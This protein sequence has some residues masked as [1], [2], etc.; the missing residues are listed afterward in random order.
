MSDGVT[1]RELDSADAPAVAALCGQLGY[2][3]TA[4]EIERRVGRLAGRDD[5]A[6]V[7]AVRGGEVVGWIH[8]CAR[9]V[10]ESEPDVE[11]AGL[12]V[13][14]RH[15]GGGIGRLLMAY[16]DR[17]AGGRGRTLVRVRS[18]VV[19]ESAHAFYKGLGFRI[20]KTQHTFVK[21]VAP[22]TP[23]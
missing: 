8:L 22:L 15:R 2:P 7:V 3:A 4:Q 10:L 6:L 13:D 14:E 20:Q 1:L 23:T 11:V 17:W 21:A 18:N 12:V 16:A 9:D 19:R 5:H